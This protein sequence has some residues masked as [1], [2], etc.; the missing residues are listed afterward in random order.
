[1]KGQWK[2]YVGEFS[3]SLPS[4]GVKESNGNKI[5]KPALPGMILTI[6]KGSYSGKKIGEDVSFHRLYAPNSPHTTVKKARDCK[7]CHANSAALG[8][9]SGELN[10]SVTNGNW[11]CTFKAEY[12]LNAND[13]L[14][15]VAWIDFLKESSKTTTN[16]TRSDFRPF[17]LK[18]QKQLLLVGACLNCHKED[19]KVMQRSLVEGIEPLLKS[20]NKK[21]ILPAWNWIY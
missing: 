17:S 4:M 2:E 3:S 5:I 6:D 11:K 16:S 21:C 15:E 9:G 8:Y 20:L 13:N 12:D 14:T 1:M 7:S 18:E 10:Y 19:S